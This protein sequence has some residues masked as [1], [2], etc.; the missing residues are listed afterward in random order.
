MTMAFAL[1]LLLGV[2]AVYGA[3]VA[4][5]ALNQRSMQY[6]PRTERIAPET[7]GL[8]GVREVLIDAADGVKLVTWRHPPAPG[9]PTVL[10]F[11]GNGGSSADR[12]FR[13]DDLI[14]AGFGL[15]APSYRGYGGSGGSPTEAGLL[16]D[17]LAAYD[18]LATS[19][20]GPIVVYGESLGSGVAVHVAAHREV[21]AM[22]LESPFTS[23]LDV[24]RNAYPI[25]PVSLLMKDRYH[26]DRLI[27]KVTSPLVIVHGDRDNVVPFELG[28]ALFELANEPKRFVS[29]KGGRHN[30]LW[31]RGALRE[32]RDAFDA[33]TAGSAR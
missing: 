4:L 5:T 12:G 7:V 8:P 2:A 33:V 9:K 22:V 3:I 29:V 13:F 21:A 30:D 23:A 17:G 26:S 25:L 18:L 27:D 14:G 24:A 19:A 6:F 10:Y 28:K 32:A 15:F 11:Q 1:K 20:D 31:E 16:A